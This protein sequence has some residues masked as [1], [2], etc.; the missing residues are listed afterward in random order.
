MPEAPRAPRTPSRRRRG[1]NASHAALS[2]R[3]WCLRWSATRS[4]TGPWHGHR[5]QDRNRSA[6]HGASQRRGG[7]AS[8]GSRRSPRARQAVHREAHD[9]VGHATR[10]A[11]REDGDRHHHERQQDGGDLHVASSRVIAVE[12]TRQRS[13]VLRST[14]GEFAAA[15]SRIPTT[16]DRAMAGGPQSTRRHST[17]GRG[18]RTGAPVATGAPYPPIRSSSSSDRALGVSGGPIGAAAACFLASFL[19]CFCSRRSRTALSRLSFAI[20][21]FFLEL[22]ADISSRRRAEHRAR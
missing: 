1:A 7:S 18:E 9:H 14:V 13:A 21:V 16:P 5:P 6:S 4:I 10:L 15:F 12:A 11:T 8:D 3:A 2:V 17:G 20:V 22:E 19:A